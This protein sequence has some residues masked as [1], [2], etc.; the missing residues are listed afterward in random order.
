MDVQGLYNLK[1]KNEWSSLEDFVFLATANTDHPNSTLNDRLMVSTE[2]SHTYVHICIC[3][4]VFVCASVYVTM[5]ICVSVFMFVCTYV[6][7]YACMCVCMY[8]TVCLCLCMYIS[9]MHI[10][11]HCKESVC[12]YKSTGMDSIHTGVHCFYIS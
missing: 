9:N 12:C 1:K 6:C 2:I 3:V 11:L 7:L 5:C 8:V 4:C 10:S